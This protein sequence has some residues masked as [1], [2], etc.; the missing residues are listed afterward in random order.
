[1]SRPSLERG[2]RTLVTPV[3]IPPDSTDRCC[4]VR[5][6]FAAQLVRRC[7]GPDPQTDLDRPV[8]EHSTTALINILGIGAHQFQRANDA[9]RARELVER[10]KAQR[11]AHDYS[12]TSA[13]HA[14]SAHPKQPIQDRKTRDKTRTSSHAEKID[15][16]ITPTGC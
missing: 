2:R 1:M 12:D 9:S 11:V 8:T 3:A 10:Q 14:R 13:E 15:R 4:F 5:L 6:S 16:S 7:I